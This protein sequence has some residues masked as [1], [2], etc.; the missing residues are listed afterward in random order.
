MPATTRCSQP[1]VAISN[2]SLH[3]ATT[4]CSQPLVARN[5]SL[6]LATTRC[7]QPLVVRNHS[8]QLA[9]TRCSQPLVV[10]NHSLQ[11]ATTRC[12]QPLVVRNHSLFATTRCSQPLV[13]VWVIFRLAG[14][15]P[16]YS[17]STFPP[18]YPFHPSS[19]PLY[20]SVSLTSRVDGKSTFFGTST[21]NADIPF[22]G[23]FLITL[24]KRRSS[25]VHIKT[26]IRD[27]INS[28]SHRISS[29]TSPVHI[30]H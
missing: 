24:V 2:H 3:L 17:S 1:L 8:L 26:S 13:A 30:N 9:T 19:P 11:L 14:F 22:L 10:R 5:H 27:Y 28:Q 29:N 16:L 6:H 7:S 23:P 12:S 20:V 18:P 4:R 21:L 25:N 15:Y